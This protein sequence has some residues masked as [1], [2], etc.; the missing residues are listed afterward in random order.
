VII[1]LSALAHA[2]GYYFSDSGI[3]A[4][5]RGGA[6]VA[7]A[8]NQFAMYHN[9]AGLIRVDAPTISAG[10][11][12][13]RQPVWFERVDEAGNVLPAVRN[14]APAFAVP[15][16]GFA[17]PVGDNAALAFGFTSPFAPT[18]DYDPDGAQRY[19]MIDSTIW[20]FSVGPAGAWRPTPWLTVGG[21]LGIQALR[22]DQRLKV[23]TSG[24]RNDGSDLPTGDILVEARTWDR[25][26]PF[27]NAGVLIEPHERVSIG[28][29]ITPPARFRAKGPGSLDFTGHSL[30]S[31]L[32]QTVWDDP[33]VTLNVDLPVVLRAGVAVR[34]RPNIEIELA[35][36][37]EGWS[38]LADIQVEDI[39]VTVTSE[40][41][42]IAREVPPTLSL[43]AGFRD[44][45]S[46]RLGGEWR[47]HERLELRAGAMWERGALAPDRLSLALVDPWKLQ[48]SVGASVWLVDGRVRFDGMASYL[49]LPTLRI[50][51]SQ[52]DQVGV[53][54]LTES[55]NTAIVGNGTL[56]SHGWTTGVRAS[57]VFTKASRATPRE[58]T[59]PPVRGAP[60]SP[61][62]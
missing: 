33:S 39:D 31:N 25:G 32:D 40:S 4:A 54:V 11:S 53:P 48:G 60:P 35:G 22:V 34:P 1:L 51:N 2:G 38:S 7:G 37:Y 59:P 24:P 28:L 55:V 20:L 5:G 47:A 41:L 46:V 30:E 57:Y 3:V 42:G 43:P 45:F 50:D 9:P 17:M 27:W 52:V 62:G 26:R 56:R 13:V 10:L 8:D 19:S 36:T 21:G 12:G 6:W 61:A 18:F 14:Q 15:E 16:L 44:N 23:T 49:H 58:T 29:A